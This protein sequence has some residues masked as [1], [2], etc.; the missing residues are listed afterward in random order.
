MEYKAVR[1]Q[2]TTSVLGFAERF[3]YLFILNHL[4]EIFCFHQPNVIWLL[5]KHFISESK[6]LSLAPFRFFPW[7]GIE[8]CACLWC[9]QTGSTEVGKSTQGCVNLCGPEILPLGAFR[10]SLSGVGSSPCS[11]TQKEGW[12]LTLMLNTKTFLSQY[13]LL[14]QLIVYIKS[15]ETWGN[16]CWSPLNEIEIRSFA[17]AFICTKNVFLHSVRDVGSF[18]IDLRLILKKGIWDLI[19]ETP[20]L[21]LQWGMW[22]ILT[23]CKY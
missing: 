1:R 10:G 7:R 16:C 20:E 11:L 15:L 4:Y 8:T 18:K 9:Q 22:I 14:L 5:E 2:C 13:F 6:Q 12:N 21:R 19:N 23:G 17:F 3:V